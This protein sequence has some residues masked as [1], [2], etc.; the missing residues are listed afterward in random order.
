MCFLLLFFSFFVF[1]G[2][3]ENTLSFRNFSIRGMTRLV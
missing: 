3:I 2:S 1:F